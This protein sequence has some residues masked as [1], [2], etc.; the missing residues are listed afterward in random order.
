MLYAERKVDDSL[1]KHQ[2]DIGGRIEWRYGADSRIIHSLGLFD[3]QGVGDGPNNQF[4]LTQAFVTVALPV[5][6]GLKITAGKFV[7]PIGL[8]TIDPTSN[9]LYSHS[10]LFGYAIPFT[11]TG[12]T[13]SYDFTTALNVTAGFTRGWDTSLEDNND[14]IDFLGTVTYKFDKASDPMSRWGGHDSQVAVSLITG[15]DQ[16]GDNSN[17]RTLVDVIVQTKVGDNLQLAFNG[18]YAYERNS[19][20][21]VS[22]SDAQWWGVA[23]YAKLT[24][25]KYVDVNLRAEY[26]NDDDGARLTGSVGGAGVFEATAGLTITP[27]PDDKY[28]KNLSLRPEVRYDYASKNFF[29][30]GTDRSQFTAAID[31]I[32]KF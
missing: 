31:A 22:G 17:Y 29:D 24:T 1:A 15:P 14:T 21:S 12:V 23:G 18:D 30:G 32:Y 5:G 11:H 26:F 9:F 16:P 28:G 25:S 3:Y 19:H 10:Y 2:F 27:L 7:T 13:A 8:E 6:N 4:D 20:S